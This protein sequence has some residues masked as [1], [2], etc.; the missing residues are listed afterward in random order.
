MKQDVFAF[1][2]EYLAEGERVAF[3]TVSETEGSSP[4]SAGQIM[5]VVADGSA[6]GTVGGGSTEHQVKLRAIEAI[7]ND[8]KVFRMSLNHGA[9]GMVCGGEMHVFG[10]V[11]G[12]DKHLC[13]FGG[14]HIAQYLAP[15]AIMTGFTVSV[16]EDRPEFES[17]FPGI[18]YIVC[19]PDSYETEL[20]IPASAYVVICTRGHASDDEA[21]RYT[22]SQPR[23]Y[24]GMIGS[25][26]KVETLF[27]R[28]RKD[29]HTEETLNA[30]FTP[31]GLDIA[32]AIPA[33]IA[34]SIMAEILLVKNNG[35]P[36]HISKKVRG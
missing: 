30:I 16:I 26:K 6:S 36:S 25:A 34:V 1:I 33:E 7:R 20:N 3:V 17:D 27:R 11:L 2:Q 18:R 13:I 29:G 31:I 8:E 35:S 12:E 32:S 22:L 19:E 5:A 24:I 23:K 14:G 10:T 28:L 21:L 4:A 9:N 15:L